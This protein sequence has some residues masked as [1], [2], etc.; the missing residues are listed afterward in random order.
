M[1]LTYRM[2]VLGF[3]LSQ[4]DKLPVF[5]MLKMQIFVNSFSKIGRVLEI[6]Y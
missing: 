6:C 1:F 2:D 5:V 3:F 4:N